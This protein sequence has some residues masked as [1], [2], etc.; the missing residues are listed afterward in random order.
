MEKYIIAPPAGSQTNAIGAKD[1]PW[2]EVH[3]K[4]YPGLNEYLAESTGYG[5]VSGC[6]PSISGLTVKVGAGVIHLADGTRKEIAQTSITLDNADQSNPRIDLVYI[7]SDGTVA[8]ITGT[9]AASPSAPALPGNGISVCNVTIAAGASTGTVN[10]VQ[11]IAPN[12]ANYDIVNVKDFGAKGDGVAD[13]TEAIQAAIDS[14]VDTQAKGAVLIP[15]GKYVINSKLEIDVAYVSIKANGATIDAS[16][17][18]SGEALHV[19]GSY[20]P[21]FYQSMNC[22][23]GF[24]LIGAGRNTDT[25]GILF[26]SST[27]STSH[28]NYFKLNINKFK[29]GIVFGSH[30]YLQNFINC[31]VS[32]C[33]TCVLMPTGYTD[34]GEKIS[35]FGCTLYN[36]NNAIEIRNS[37][38]AFFITQTSIDYTQHVATVNAGVLFLTDCHIES[39]Y[40]GTGEYEGISPFTLANT[41]GAS[42]TVEGGILLNT[43]PTVGYSSIIDNQNTNNKVR[44]SFTNVFIHNIKY[45]DAFSSGNGI[46][47]VEGTKSFTITDFP[48]IVSEKNNLMGNGDFANGTINDRI[49]IAEDT[50]AISGESLSGTNIKLTTSNE[51]AYKGDYSLKA[52]KTYGSGS[53]AAFEILCPIKPYLLTTFSFMLYTPNGMP[54]EF[55]VSASYSKIDGAYRCGKSIGAINLGGQSEFKDGFKR[56]S[57][58]TANNL[59]APS[60]ATHIKVSLNLNKVSSAAIY[61][62]DIVVN[63][64]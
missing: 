40:W 11:T 63:Q 30:S 48:V 45:V 32:D 21:P 56:V 8:K 47:K 3:A 60:W 36:S 31:D 62:D 53:S 42:L 41:N 12:L 13:D 37:D 22:L 7:T 4:R 55:W 33:K 35:F 20:Y 1:R 61:V 15:T 10:R 25:I 54:N 16:N 52:T 6:E 34:Y 19:Y 17:I 50:A 14:L 64:F 18:T 59:A 24:E 57:I 28:T 38:G 43:A 5:I 51:Y 58:V 26:D 2:E 23:E 46:T 49:Y 39:R 9:A 27:G 29:T 44:A